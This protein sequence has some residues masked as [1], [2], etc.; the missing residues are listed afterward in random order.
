MTLWSVHLFISLAPCAKR[1]TSPAGRK[2][3]ESGDSCFTTIL[4]N[5]GPHLL[6]T[7]SNYYLNMLIFQTLAL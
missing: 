1:A 2:R 5:E 4:L 7:F 3:A 6:I